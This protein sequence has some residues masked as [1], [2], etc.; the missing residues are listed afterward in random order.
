MHR[1]KSKQVHGS[2]SKEMHRSKSKKMRWQKGMTRKM[3]WQKMMPRQMRCQKGMTRHNQRLALMPL[4][5][6]KVEQSRQLY[7]NP[8]THTSRSLVEIKM[9]S[10][11]QKQVEPTAVAGALIPLVV[12][13]LNGPE[14]VT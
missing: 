5:F 9:K 11:V 4:P 2:K 10:G 3:R 12:V 8:Q 7:M 13:L 6:V 14:G 1:S